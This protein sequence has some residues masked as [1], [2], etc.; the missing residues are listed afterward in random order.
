MTAK[1]KVGRRLDS[2]EDL[3]RVLLQVGRESRLDNIRARLK[4]IHNFHAFKTV[5]SQVGRRF[6]Y[7][8]PPGICIEKDGRSIWKPAIPSNRISRV[9]RFQS[10]KLVS[11]IHYL[12]QMC[13]DH[14]RLFPAM[15][16]RPRRAKETEVARKVFQ[17]YKQIA[18]WLG[19]TYRQGQRKYESTEEALSY[20]RSR[21][22]S[23]Q[24]PS[25]KSYRLTK[26]EWTAFKRHL[27]ENRRI[28][29]AKLA[30]ALYAARF[31]KAITEKVFPSDKQLLNRHS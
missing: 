10:L 29:P 27:N 12:H 3:R 9:M 11:Q 15:R 19:R 24:R 18:S 21:V 28:S 14:A 8:F 20:L 30:A 13:L 2:L 6:L 23:L 31:E 22:R 16:G 4:E 7:K 1:A 17:V 26:W 5:V 25:G